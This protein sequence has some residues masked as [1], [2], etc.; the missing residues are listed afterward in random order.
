M[1][2]SNGRNHRNILV[3]HEIHGKDF[4]ISVYSVFS[5][6]NFLSLVE[7]RPEDSLCQ[8]FNVRLNTLNAPS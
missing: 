4:L 6:V 1:I 8:L 7:R 5:V 2:D 3:D